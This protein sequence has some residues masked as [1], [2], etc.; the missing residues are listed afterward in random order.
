MHTAVEDCKE[1]SLLVETMGA[2]VLVL[3]PKTGAAEAE[4]HLPK[5]RVERQG[6]NEEI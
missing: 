1:P 4:A 5:V 2:D 3:G 6:R